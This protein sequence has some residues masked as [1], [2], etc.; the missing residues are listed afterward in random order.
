MYVAWTT[1]A[2]RTDAETL[3]ST[4]VTRGLAVCVQIDG[5]IISHYRWQGRAERS[6]EF[7]LTIKCT[8]TQLLAVES[9]V[10]AHHPYET[11][12][13]IVVQA[14]RVGEKYLSW[15]EASSTNPP[16]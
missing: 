10:L 12:E 2:Q 15:A 8:S 7:R 11:P 3:A 6:A 16:L 5:P 1:V 9:H 4:L 13:W 14:D